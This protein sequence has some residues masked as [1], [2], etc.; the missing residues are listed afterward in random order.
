MTISSL[1]TSC[2]QSTLQSALKQRLT[3]FKALKSAL[4]GGDLASAQKAFSALEQD[5]KA[6]TSNGRKAPSDQVSQDMDALKTALGSN[7]LSGSQSAFATLTQ[8]LQAERKGHGAPHAA[9]VDN[10]NFSNTTNP[11]SQAIDEFIGTLL[12]TKA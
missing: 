7:D 8:D 11:I 12:N 9:E 4:D 6:L 1:N 2:Y 3:D 5:N 10:S